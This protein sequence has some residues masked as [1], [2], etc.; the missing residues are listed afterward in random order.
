MLNIHH[1]YCTHTHTRAVKVKTYNIQVNNSPVW[2]SSDQWTHKM[3]ATEARKTEETTSYQKCLMSHCVQF[4]SLY[5]V[6]E[7]FDFL[8]LST[9]LAC[10]ALD[11][12]LYLPILSTLNTTPCYYSKSNK[13]HKKQDKNQWSPSGWIQLYTSIAICSVFSWWIQCRSL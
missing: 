11:Q 4:R 6:L 3:G 2:V 9:C 8:I 13:D 5:I 7:Y 1:H 10:T 12:R